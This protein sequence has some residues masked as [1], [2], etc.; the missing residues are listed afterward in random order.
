L[1]DFLFTSDEGF[2]ACS[3]RYWWRVVKVLFVVMPTLT[4]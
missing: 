4:G 1:E 3:Q 2:D